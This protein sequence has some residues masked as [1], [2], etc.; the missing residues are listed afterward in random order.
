MSPRK[1]R[2]VMVISAVIVAIIVVVPSLYLLQTKQNNPEITVKE[3]SSSYTFTGDFF[4]AYSYPLNFVGPNAATLIAE[5]GYYNFSTHASMYGGVED[6]GGAWHSPSI[7]AVF[8]FTGKLPYDLHPS[9]L[10]ISLNTINGSG[11]VFTSYVDN[12]YQYDASDF[13]KLP[14]NVSEGS[15]VVNGGHNLNLKFSNDTGL[16]SNQSFNFSLQDVIN[17]QGTDSLQYNTTYGIS[18]TATLEGL[19][20]PVSTTLFLFL[21]DIPKG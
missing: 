5:N 17:I 2:L 14:V 19:P 20:E 15:T 18:V 6:I 21:I 1:K 13:T 7:G 8:N 9:G 12:G 16:K 3:G 11:P 10:R 4:S